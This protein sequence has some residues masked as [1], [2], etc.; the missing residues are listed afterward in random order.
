MI[1]HETIERVMN[2]AQIEE[3]VSDY[4]VLRKRGANLIGLCPFHNEKTGSFTVSPAKGIYK[5]FGCG[6]AG[7]AVGFIMAIENCSYV[8]AIRH[9]A[10]KYHIEIEERA[11]TAEEQQRHDDRESMFVLNEYCAKWYQ[12]QLWNTQ[13]GQAVGL[14]YLRERGL[15]DETIRR[16]QIGF[17]PRGSA[18]PAALKKEGFVEK[19][20]VCDPETGI[21]TGVCCRA[22]DGRLFDRFSDRV[23]FPC[24]TYSGKT[25]SFAGRILRPKEN[26]GKYVNSPESVIFKKKNE[27]FGLYQA[28]EEIR[29]RSVCYL[30]EG[31][32][33]VISLH[34]AGIRN[35]VASGGTS[36]TQGQVALIGRSMTTKNIVVLYDGDNAGIKAAIKGLDMFLREGFNAKVV[37]LPEG[38]DPDSYARSHNASEVLEYIESHQTDFI[39]FKIALLQREA[40]DD[41]QAQAAL[42]HNVV[43]SI[44]CIPDRI[45]RQVYVR[46][47]A[48]RLGDT[49]QNIAELVE[50]ARRGQQPPQTTAPA[51]AATPKTAQT[52]I[53]R[54]AQRNPVAKSRLETNYENLLRLIIRSGERPLY[55]GADGSVWTV[56]DYILA[57]LEQD[58]ALPA[59]PLYKRIIDLYRAHCH[60]TGFTAENYFKSL[61]IET[62]DDKAVS[63]FVFDMLTDRYLLS[64]PADE[65]G[66]Q[67]A[68]DEAEQLTALVPQFLLEL[69][70]TIA[71]QRIEEVSRQIKEKSET[72]DLESLRPLM[73]LGKQL[74]A[75]RN[76]VSKQL[77]RMV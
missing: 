43:S 69:K 34:Q 8:E 37:L 56:A 71:E 49:E 63:R 68:E 64:Q 1:P 74:Q 15:T 44:A 55:Q 75:Y 26:V 7:N 51:A 4:V 21:G 19:Y 14:S 35:V 31:Q 42:I 22:T 18:L 3:V 36:L 29:R 33:D 40:Q 24:H 54:Q 10:R 13:E 2:A 41:E 70:L 66:Q 17:S 62:D 67:P 65:E 30:V 72:G 50:A 61:P 25:V 23:I 39:R 58:Q 45:T 77:G 47:A 16:F 53:Q 12:D 27:L 73:T 48:Q 60:D 9:L 20:I 76:E 5:C 59:D 46:S 32:M 28:K 52:D 6:V 38:E 11:L 57:Q